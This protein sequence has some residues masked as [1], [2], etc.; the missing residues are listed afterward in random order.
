MCVE[1][2][3]KAAAQLANYLVEHV[4][5]GAGYEFGGQ[6]DAYKLKKAAN[7]DELVNALAVLVDAVDFNEPVTINLCY[8]VVLSHFVFYLSV[9]CYCVPRRKSL[10]LRYL[11]EHDAKLEYI[12]DIAKKL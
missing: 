5:E 12:C 8:C 11:L 10:T 7:S 4:A 3:F 6:V 1:G 9:F 2:Y